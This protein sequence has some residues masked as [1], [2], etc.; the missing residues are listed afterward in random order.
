[1]PPKTPSPSDAIYARYSSDNQ[2]EASIDDQVRVC[3]QY[4]ERQGLTVVAEYED[5]AISVAST[6]RPGYQS[7]LQNASKGA[8]DIV[9]AE[10]LDRLS[11]DLADVATL[12]KHLSYLGIGLW[13]VAE[14]EI[15]ELHEDLA[16]LRGVLGGRTAG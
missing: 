5:A 11:R 15:T 3:R 10:A 16:R 13:T 6:L 2:S 1:M 8:F 12:Y 7:L 14:G 4:A 9:L